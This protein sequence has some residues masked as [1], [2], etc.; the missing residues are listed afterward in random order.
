MSQVPTVP[1]QHRNKATLNETTLSKGL[2]HS[3][4][5]W[6]VQG[7]VAMA[8]IDQVIMSTHTKLQKEEHVIWAPHRAKF[9][10]PSCQ[11][12]HVSKKWSCI[13]FNEDEFEDMVAKKWLILDGCGVKYIPNHVPLDK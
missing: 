13:K 11:E 1:H 9:K 12:I 2:L 10:F 5:L 7:T 3:G 8:H 4:C 6:K